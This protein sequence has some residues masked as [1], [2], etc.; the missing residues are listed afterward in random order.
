M[1]TPEIDHLLDR[2]AELAR[3]A[4]G[5]PEAVRA[6][7]I[8]DRLR[9]GRFSI[10]VVGEFKRGKST[11]V[12]ALVGEEVVPTG[13]LPL[14]AVR[15]EL[16]YGAPS[17]TVVHLD[18]T[19]RRIERSEV[20]DYVAEERNPANEKKVARVVLRGRWD[21]LIG[22]V[23][24]VDTPGVGSV[25]EHNTEEARAALVDTDGA[26][27]VLA[28]DAPLSAAERDMLTALAGRQAPTFFVLNKVDH[29]TP[30]ELAQVRAFVG[31][32]I[33]QHLGRSER[34]YEVDARAAL[35]ARLE[36][37]EPSDGFDFA[38]LM[39]DLSRFVKDDLVGAL[40][41]G[42]RRDL[43]ELGRSLVEALAVEE[44]ALQIDSAELARRA[45]EFKQ[46]AEEQRRAFVDDRT[47]LRR[48][49]AE[50]TQSVR[51]QLDELAAAEPARYFEDL[52]R[53]AAGAPVSRLSDEL[54]V[55]VQESVR[56]SFDRF[57]ASEAD[58][59]EREWREIAE[60]FRRRTEERV[61]AVRQAASDL[62][63]IAL[64][65]LEIPAIAS[66]RERFFYL[67]LHV[68]NSVDL[69]SGFAARLVPARLARPRALRK[70]RE[71]LVREFAKHAGR[72][73]WDLQ[74]RLEGACRELE[75][76]M[77]SELASCAETILAAAERAES[78]RR[79]LVQRRDQ[80]LAEAAAQRRLAE[81][82]IGLSQR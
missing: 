24:L 73:G 79:E 57:R 5:R 41:R 75:R 20:A 35:K 74:Q 30:D 4:E 66:E 72:A 31:K 3:L 48:D 52:E 61:A 70:A 42:A 10:S 53:V 25:Y 38:D 40:S 65:R 9:A 45:E 26:I 43:A 7:R 77:E 19:L 49:V 51:S 23:E 63:N 69:L 62:F 11:L 33:E 55:A 6:T 78:R 47:L 37:A 46:A 15:T 59:A 58:L 44:A 21:L 16:A 12:N 71:E 68:G 17:S 1:S 14:T 27:V 8:A 34:V 81:E 29:L 36:G 13:V 80:R 64:P 56:A 60:N 50:L 54:W 2:A 18:G 32:A 22:G 82:L 67:F 39:A 28:A 76:A